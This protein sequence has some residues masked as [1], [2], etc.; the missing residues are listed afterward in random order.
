MIQRG[1][2]R[3]LLAL[4]LGVLSA[5]NEPIRD[6]AAS[7]LGPEDPAVP[8]G[9][10]H[11]PGQPCAL[12]HDGDE[13]RALS[14]GGTVY[15]AEGS[16]VPAVGASV[17]LVD[18]VGARFSATTNCVGNFFVLPEDFLPNY[19]VWVHLKRGDWEIAMESP[20]NGDG[21]CASCHAR[22]KGPESAGHVYLY[23]L[24]PSE[25]P[26]ECP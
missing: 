26:P 5:C 15:W 17:E 21:S 19:P 14:F 1:A 9:P 18:S 12:C 2:M 6:R 8:A 24:A 20:V 10:L 25:A 23:F 3:G 16:D 11:R 4:F 7:R 22:E 13:A